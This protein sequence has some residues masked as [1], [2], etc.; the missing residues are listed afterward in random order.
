MAYQSRMQSPSMDALFSAILSLENIEE[1]YRFFEDVCTAAELEA[2]S[3]RFEVARMLQAKCTYQD[4]AEK[5]GASSATISR[6]KRSLRYGAD[7][8][9]IILDRMREAQE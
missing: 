4:I 9:H 1:C 2:L 7:G 6:V 5:T 3:Q 8:Y